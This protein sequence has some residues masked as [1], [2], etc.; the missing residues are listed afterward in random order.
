MDMRQAK[1]AIQETARRYGVSE[2]SV[3]Q[4]IEACILDAVERAKEKGDTATLRE[5]K[6]M[7]SSGGIPTAYEAVAYMGDKVSKMGQP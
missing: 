4:R 7:S 1:K 3:V 5:W 6:A 2:K